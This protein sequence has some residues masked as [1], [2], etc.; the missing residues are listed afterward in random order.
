MR[1]AQAP[2]GSS[3]TMLPARPFPLGATV[4]RAGPALPSL[5]AATR[6]CCCAFEPTAGPAWN[7][8][9]A[10]AASRSHG[11]PRSSRAA[12]AD[13]LFHIESLGRYPYLSAPARQESLLPTLP[14]PL[15]G[16]GSRENTRWVITRT[17][18]PRPFAI[19]EPHVARCARVSAVARTYRRTMPHR[20]I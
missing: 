9:Q 10:F 17:F 3:A 14:V 6:G 2:V 18:R 16:L 1:V 7:L 15:A 5:R 20:S 11:W 19:L 8:S 4:M 12:Q 13:T